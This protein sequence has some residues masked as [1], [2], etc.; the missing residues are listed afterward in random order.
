MMGSGAGRPTRRSRP[1]Q[2]GR[3]RSAC[4]R[5]A[6]T[7]PSAQQRFVRPRCPR[8]V[9]TLVVLDRTK[10]PGAVGRAALPGR[11]RVALEAS[12]EGRAAA[13]HPPPIG[14]RYGLSSKEFT[15]AMVAGVLRRGRRGQA[16]GTTSRSASSTTS[17]TCSLEGPE[18]W[19]PSPTTS[20]R[21]VFYGLGSRRHR[22]RQQELG[23]DHRRRH[24]RQ[25][26]PG[27]LRL[28]LEEGRC[29]HGL[30]PALRSRGRSA[31]PTSSTRQDFVGLPPVGLPRADVDVLLERG[32]GATSSCSTRPT[33]PDEIWDTSCPRHQRTGSSTRS[34]AST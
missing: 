26:C 21:A 4:S 1:R 24:D 33:V 32:R 20:C 10:E 30:A 2:P 13:G 16:A 12:N 17:R 5:S 28:R 18:D 9:K 22:R 23:E 11:R 31:R 3:R 15:P 14:G 6:S 25:L 27:L 34:S 7:A 19:S 29:D 8:P